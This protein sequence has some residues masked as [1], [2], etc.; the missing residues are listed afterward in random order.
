MLLD[1]EKFYKSVADY[2]KS[3]DL[4]GAEAFLAEKE[5]EIRLAVIPAA[6]CST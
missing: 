3:Q 5:K 4:E 6:E 1:Y 2:Y